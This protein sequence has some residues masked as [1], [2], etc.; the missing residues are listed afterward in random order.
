M[1][2]PNVVLVVCDQ[3]SAWTLGA[4]GAPFG[5]TPH[6]DALASGGLNFSNAY[7]SYPVCVPAR[8]SMMTG[9]YA[10]RVGCVDNASL[11]GSDIPT[12]AHHLSAAGYETVLTGKMHF[13]GPDQ[14]HG[15]E[16]RL[17][18][19][20]YPA[21]FA[22]LPNRDDVSSFRHVDHPDAKP[23]AID[24]VT[25]GVRQWSDGLEYDE[26][27][28]LR[29]LQFIRSRRTQ[30]GGSEQ[31]PP[32][33]REEHRPYLL[34]VSYHHPHEPFHVPQDLWDRFADLD[35]GLPAQ[36]PDLPQSQMDRWVN[37]FHGVDDV[38]LHDPDRLT[39]LR[40]AYLCLVAYIDDKVGH[41]IEVLTETG[42]R[43]DTVIMFTSDHGDMLGERG[44][45]QKRC[46]YEPSAN[47]PL[48]VNGPGRVRQGIVDTPVSLVD[49]LPTILNI[50]S[51]ENALPVDGVNIVEDVLDPAR[52][53]YSEY[54]SEG[55]YAPCFAVRSGRYKLIYVHGDD[56]QLFDVKDDPGERVD[57]A[58]RPELAE[59]E[60]ALVEQLL[61]EFD[62]DAIEQEIRQSLARRRLIKAAMS[63]SGT[64]WD[65]EPRVDPTRQ[66]WRFD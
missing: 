8:A 58:G 31:L 7:T 62:P 53:I 42:Q 66:Y 28:H 55:V 9:R 15:F 29:A 3:M 4:L 38:P 34:C 59:V 65:H 48:I 5:V 23:L 41:L 25:A 51:V 17:T 2:R 33:E 30:V 46:F 16:R 32:P 21:N 20:I 49:V 11:Y 64:H 36:D 50:A 47:I 22:W 10:S 14:L 40:R 54:H 61:G 27:T 24:Y 35:V 18:T 45:V 52:T 19:D 57:L 6:L 44:M 37:A 13:I 39:Q 26:E 1:K 43:D 60:N 56:H 12:V 63:R